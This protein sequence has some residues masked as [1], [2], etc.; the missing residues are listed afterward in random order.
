VCSVVSRGLKALRS[1]QRKRQGREALA[2]GFFASLLLKRIDIS[3][4]QLII[5]FVR[6]QIDQQLGS[7][8][9]FLFAD[10]ARCRYMQT[11]TAPRR[12]V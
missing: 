6:V 9:K 8:Q 3:F 5:K 1:S 11:D 7:L 2:S 4:G 12:R 10:A